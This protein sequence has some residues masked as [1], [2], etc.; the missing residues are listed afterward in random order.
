MYWNSYLKLFLHIVT[1]V[2]YYIFFNYAFKLNQ[3]GCGCS[4]NMKRQFI[5]YYAQVG[6]VI[7]SIKLLDNLITQRVSKGILS[8]IYMLD[9]IFGFIFLIVMYQFTKEL[10]ENKCKCSNTWERDFMYTYSKIILV[11][12]IFIFFCSL[13]AIIHTKMLLK[14]IIIPL[15]M[16]YKGLKILAKNK[17]KLPKLKI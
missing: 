3:Y 9:L 12:Y 16:A 17:G 5:K 11:I 2:L 7:V 10:K 4:N 6:I 8:T 13:S 1:L 14:T 15:K